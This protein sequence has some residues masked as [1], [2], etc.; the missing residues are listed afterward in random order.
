MQIWKTRVDSWQ[1]IHKISVT[2]EMYNV[3]HVKLIDVVTFENIV[4]N[5]LLESSN[6]IYKIWS[7]PSELFWLKNVSRFIKIWRQ[8]NVSRFIKIWC[9]HGVSWVFCEFSSET[10]S[11]QHL[12]LRA[13]GQAGSEHYFT[14]VP[15]VD[16]LFCALIL[17]FSLLELL[18]SATS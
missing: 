6:S 18:P 14:N 11:V 3:V 12:R 8:H 2:K 7:S 10:Y 15:V 13:L 9:Q 16:W 17:L 5:Y 1:Y 4:C